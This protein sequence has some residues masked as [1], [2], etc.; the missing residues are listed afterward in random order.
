M[1][2]TSE[3]SAKIKAK[4][5]EYSGVDDN[6]LATKMVE[7][8][9]EYKSQ[10]DI[11]GGGWD[12]GKMASDTASAVG[13]AGAAAVGTVGKGLAYGGKSVLDATSYV[14]PIAN[15][16]RVK[17]MA[18]G[19]GFGYKSPLLAPGEA[20]GKLG[21]NLADQAMKG[22]VAMS[23]GQANE[24]AQTGGTILGDI[25]NATLG[26]LAGGAGV[27]GQG[28]GNWVTRNVAETVGAKK[29]MTGQDANATDIGTGLAIGGAFEAAR[30]LGKVLKG[31]G[32]MASKLYNAAVPP[33]KKEAALVQR[34]LA[35]LGAKPRTIA[36][37][38]REQGI[39]GTESSIGV[40]SL[41][42]AEEINNNVIQPVLRKAKTKFSIAKALDNI[43]KEIQQVPE[44][45]RRKELLDGL[46]AVADDYKGQDL[47]TWTKA[48]KIKSG[49]DT[50]TPSKIF[51]GKEVAN[52]YTQVRN[53]LANEIRQGTYKLL[54]NDELKNAYLD[55]GNLLQSSEHGTTAMTGADFKK[56]FGSFWSTVKDK[57][58]VPALTM[59]GKGAEKVG[60]V[61]RKLS[62]PPNITSG[63]RGVLPKGLLSKAAE[64]TARSLTLKK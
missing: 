50:F 23:G 18:T 13:Q 25:A 58:A 41:K 9:P 26:S 45:G 34:N 54:P 11:G 4:Y 28:L 39:A 40:Q 37:T 29:M 12:F 19:S 63:I 27:K 62:L 60:N 36:D 24:L 47:T 20:I 33:T 53:K 35:G 38:L 61:T 3:F 17:E 57:A 51:N 43:K 6:T 48:Q 55:V 7:K 32:N 22:S 16:Q 14:D 15:A 49:L 44:M 31:D 2:S 59:A 5:P 10:V 64:T 21:E 56:G 52:G 46:A 42:K 1:L 30:G 8:Y